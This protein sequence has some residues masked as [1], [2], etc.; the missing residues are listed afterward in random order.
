MHITAT[1]I[2]LYHVCHRELWLHAHEIRMEHTSDTVSEGKL[3]HETAYPQRAERYREVVMSGVKIDYYDPKAKV[4]HEIKKSDKVEEAHLAQVKFYLYILEQNG[5][6]GATGL[7]EYPTLRKTET[8]E[9][10]PSDRFDI[11]RWLGGITTLL[12][13]AVCPPLWRKPICKKC[14]YYEF[15]YVGE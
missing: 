8:V 9:L 13:S 12:P 5:I 2:N 7:I 10:S 4:V 15:G 14:S 6:E 3:I 1:H 11:V